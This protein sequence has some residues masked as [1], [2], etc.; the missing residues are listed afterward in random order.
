M[1]I[2]H[3]TITQCEATKTI[4]FSEAMFSPSLSSSSSLCSS[5]DGWNRSELVSPLVA[6]PGWCP[7]SV[8][9]ANGDCDSPPINLRVLS[10]SPREILLKKAELG[11]IRQYKEQDRLLTPPSL[12]HGVSE[13]FLDWE[14]GMRLLYT[15]TMDDR[16]MERR[17]TRSGLVLCYQQLCLQLEEAREELSTVRDLKRE[18]KN[19]L[20]ILEQD[21]D[22]LLSLVQTSDAVTLRSIASLQNKLKQAEIKLADAAMKIGKEIPPGSFRRVFSPISECGQFPAPST[23]LP[24]LSQ[25]PPTWDSAPILTNSPSVE[26]PT[27]SLRSLTGHPSMYDIHSD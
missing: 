27:E 3:F 13:T 10:R 24:D 18:L 14:I 12:A 20:K 7:V 9:A 8:T 23:I 15:Q 5:G 2:S 25:P 19:K 26:A 16:R 22:C 6:R 1:N 4:F 11:Q 21:E 17:G